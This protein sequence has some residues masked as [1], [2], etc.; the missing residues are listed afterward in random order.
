M[1]N[2]QQKT[3]TENNQNDHR[4]KEDTTAIE[5]S[6]FPGFHTSVSIHIL[7]KKTTTNITRI[8]Y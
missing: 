4:F 7:T 8:S 2:M 3:Q 5:K 6:R 1:K